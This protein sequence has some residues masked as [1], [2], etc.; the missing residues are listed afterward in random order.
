MNTY[1]LCNIV[2]NNG[3]VCISV[4]HRCKRLVSLLSGGIPYLKFHSGII[5]ERY[6]LGKECCADRGLSEI[7]ELILRSLLDIDRR[8]AR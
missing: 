1:S 3:T 2:D 8:R 4:V 6:C 7:I 5:V